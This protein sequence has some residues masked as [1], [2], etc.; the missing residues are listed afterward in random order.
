MKNNFISKFQVNKTATRKYFFTVM[1]LFFSMN[2][3]AQEAKPTSSDDWMWLFGNG[4][5]DALLGVIIFLLIIMAVLGGVLKNVAHLGIDR[6]KNNGGKV[7]GVIAFILLLSSTSNSMAQSTA[8]R[9][10]V[11]SDYMGLGTGLFYIMIVFIVIEI[12]IIIVLISSIQMLI[13]QEG[14][15]KINAP[16]KRTEPTIID[17]LSGMVP[18]EEEASILL[19]HNYDGIRELDNDL[20]PW[21][22]YGFYI[23]IIFAILYLTLHHITKTSDL[24]IAQYD[25]SMEEGRIARE[26]YQKKDMNNV[27][28]SNVK[29]ITDKAQLEEGATL[30]KDNCAVCHGKLAEGII[31]P[32]L[33]DEYWLHGGGIKN[34]FKTIKNG[35]PD[36][37]MKSWQA[38]FSPVKINE[39]ASYILSLAGT[40]PPNGKAPQGDT[41]AEEST[42]KSDSTKTDSTKIKS[43]AIDSTKAGKKKQK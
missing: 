43:Q 41:Y 12:I 30:F 1:A 15:T 20:P 26:E 36:K 16:A 29:V 14:T 40:R 9:I 2:S 13:R 42:A 34:I 10:A 8:E 23:T 5:F 32:N 27:T 19:D 37:G 4:L 38:D 6:K 35:W 25:K 21:W 28:E 39:L 3:F 33:T 11:T 24:Q 18:I 22:K 7:A 31:G 17:K